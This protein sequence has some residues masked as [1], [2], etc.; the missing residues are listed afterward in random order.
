ML[1][2][3]LAELGPTASVE[4]QT[5]LLNLPIVSCGCGCGCGY[6]GRIGGRGEGTGGG[7]REREERHSLG[8]KMGLYTSKFK[9]VEAW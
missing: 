8:V 1:D 9:S 7:G 4:M 6:V 5:M 3:C 2:L